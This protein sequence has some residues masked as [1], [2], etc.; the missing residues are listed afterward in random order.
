MK[1]L[2]DTQVWI[3]MRSAPRRLSARVRRQLED[4]RNDLL[5]S[6]AVPWEIALKVRLGK[7]RLPCDVEEYVGTR[8]AETR[9]TPLPITQLHAME[10]AALPLHHLDPFDRILIAQAR[11]E[12]VAILSADS[13]FDAYDVKLIRA[14]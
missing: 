8:T 5:L 13:A 11:L 12:S 9:V 4:E 10:S 6:A 1:I 3:W 2:L 14:R 7:L